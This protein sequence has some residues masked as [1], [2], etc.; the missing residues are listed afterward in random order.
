MQAARYPMS[1]VDHADVAA[2]RARLADLDTPD[3]PGD[4]EDQ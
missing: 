2:L 1:D 4:G 3:D